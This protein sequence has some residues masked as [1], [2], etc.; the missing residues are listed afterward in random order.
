MNANERY[1]GLIYKPI[2]NDTWDKIANSDSVDLLIFSALYG[3]LRFNE[4]ILNY[5]V[6]MTDNMVERIKLNKFS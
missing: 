5:N 4:P 6:M 2:S 3:L 1:T